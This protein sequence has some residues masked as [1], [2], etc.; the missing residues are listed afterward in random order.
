[1]DE[2]EYKT[3]I[4]MYQKKCFE[5]FNSNVKLEFKIKSLSKEIQIL[6]DENQKLKSNQ[7]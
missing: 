2:N 3:L 1:M 6:M 5:L 4:S 7:V